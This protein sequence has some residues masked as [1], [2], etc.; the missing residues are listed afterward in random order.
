MSSPDSQPATGDRFQLRAREL[1]L[2]VASGGG[3]PATV[4]GILN[5][6]PDSFS[7]GGK[8]LDSARAVTHAGTM[9]LEGASIIDVG[10]SSSRP[11]GAVYGAGAARLSP[12]EEEDRILPVIKQI[13]DRWP[14]VMISVDTFSASVAERALAAGAHIVNDITG[15]RADPK[16]AALIAEHDVPA[17]LMHSIGE[18][19]NM[20]H[21]HT[22]RLQGEDVIESIRDD[23]ARMVDKALG[24]GITQ[25]V[26]DPGFGFGKSTADNLKLIASINKFVSL[27]WPVLIGVSR[28][29]AIGTVL[30]SADAPAPVE[31]RLYGSLGATAVAILKG[32]NIVRTHD[33]RPTSEMLTVLEASRQES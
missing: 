23:L 11:R 13:A 28:K 16:M 22:A 26:V 27:G 8:Y 17:I 6:T 10:G 25:I 7:D 20:P 4:M 24:A 5:V 2:N 19:G 21:V 30:G 29:S 31:E 12:E 14:S 18:P 32:A 1:R 15:L 33:V 9:I 3:N